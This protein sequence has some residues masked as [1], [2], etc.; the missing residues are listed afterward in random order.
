MHEPLTDLSRNATY[1]GDIDLDQNFK[2]NTPPKE[3]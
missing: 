3:K 1:N 2:E